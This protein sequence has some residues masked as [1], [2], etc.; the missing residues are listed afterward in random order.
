M[1]SS[2]IRVGTF[3]TLVGQPNIWYKVSYISDDKQYINIEGQSLSVLVSKIMK[4][5]N[6]RK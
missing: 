1:I 5:S 6:K 2:K 4:Y 3:V